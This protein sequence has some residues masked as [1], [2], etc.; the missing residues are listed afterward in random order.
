MRTSQWFSN[1][2]DSFAART[3]VAA[4]GGAWSRGGRGLLLFLLRSRLLAGLILLLLLAGQYSTAVAQNTEDNAQQKPDAS[5]QNPPSDLQGQKLAIDRRLDVID[6]QLYWWK[7]V[8]VRLQTQV[9][10][11]SAATPP[12]KEDFDKLAQSVAQKDFARAK[13]ELQHLASKYEVLN[14]KFLSLTGT[15]QQ[16]DPDV[17]LILSDW[18]AKISQAVQPINQDLNDLF[19]LAYA[20]EPP[21]AEELNDFRTRLSPDV[22]QKYKDALLALLK[23][24]LDTANKNKDSLAKEQASLQKQ[25]DAITAKLAKGKLE[26]NQVAIELGLPL[27]CGTVLL[28]LSIPIVVQT[29]SKASAGSAE[30]VRAIFASGILVEIITVLLLTMSILILGLANKIEGPVLGTLLGGISGYVLN[31]LRS[32]TQATTGEA[33]EGTSEQRSESKK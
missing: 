18:D 30:Q 28:M 31:R 11:L 13:S 3:I 8:A 27:F 23:S 5:L 25:A 2:P 17:S 4:G 9:S 14:A 33:N 19:R 29:F 16:M 22:F 15:T 7:F 6:S 10:T 12:T 1:Y 20:S 32:K 21:R 24:N 26:I